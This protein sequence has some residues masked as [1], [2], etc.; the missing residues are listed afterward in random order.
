MNLCD[1]A[2]EVCRKFSIFSSS[3]NKKYEIENGLTL[4]AVTFIEFDLNTVCS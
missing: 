3:H 1:S 2:G 4:I